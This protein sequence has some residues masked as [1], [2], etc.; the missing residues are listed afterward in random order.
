MRCICRNFVPVKNL[1]GQTAWPCEYIRKVA[2]KRPG[3]GRK[4]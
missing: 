2:R 4:R 3:K 1:V